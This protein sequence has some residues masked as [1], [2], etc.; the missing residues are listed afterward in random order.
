MR[1]RVLS[2]RKVLCCLLCDNVDVDFCLFRCCCCCCCCCYWCAVCLSGYRTVV[3]LIGNYGRVECALLCLVYTNATQREAQEGFG[4]DLVATT[5][6]AFYF[7][8]SLL[9]E[10]VLLAV[11]CLAFAW[12]MLFYAATTVL[13]PWVVVSV[14]RGGRGRWWWWCVTCQLLV[15]FIPFFFVLR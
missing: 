1:V 14:E 11:P 8:S 5:V 12:T 9:V 2:R 10:T 3:I 13:I 6:C 4:R 15:L 7:D